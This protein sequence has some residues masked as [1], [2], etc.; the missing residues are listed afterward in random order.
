MESVVNHTQLLSSVDPG[1]PMGAGKRTEAWFCVRT[2]PKHE[3]IAAAQLR[4]GRDIEVFL[5]R[6]RYKRRTR[7]GLAWVT[8]AL[9]R[10]Y[11]F[12]RFDLDAAWRR[13]QGARSVR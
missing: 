13:V 8:E 4:Q 10:D 12:A 7:L 6:I 2:Q 9:F 3:H 1:V 11:L 5:P